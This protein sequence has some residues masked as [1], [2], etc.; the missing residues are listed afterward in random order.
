L[1]VGQVVVSTSIPR[2][3]AI[4]HLAD[5]I[6]VMYLHTQMLELCAPVGVPREEE[7]SWNRGGK[8]EEVRKVIE[9]EEDVVEARDQQVIINRNRKVNQ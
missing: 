4:G 6:R 8:F 3:G 2:P 1:K 5:V 9:R 7:R